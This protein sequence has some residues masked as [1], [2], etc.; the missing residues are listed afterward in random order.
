[1]LAAHSRLLARLD[2]ELERDHG[3]PL[4]SYEVLMYLGDADGGHLR[5]GELADRLLLSRSGITRLADRLERQGLIGRRRCENDGRGLYA[6]L[7]PAGRDKL[8]AAR[9]AHLAGVR[10]H[11]ISRLA[12]DEIEEL[13]AIWQRLLA[14]EAAPA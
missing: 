4:T 13:G 11:F 5:M 10:R 6:Y 3:L 14:D 8:A 2:A 1:M 12:P 9:P 7:T